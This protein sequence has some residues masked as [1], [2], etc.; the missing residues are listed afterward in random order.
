MLMVAAM[1]MIF[2]TVAAPTYYYFKS[3]S[4]PAAQQ[5]AAPIKSIAV[6]PFKPIGEKVD[7]EKFGFGMTDAVI[8]NLSKIRKVSVRST[9]AVSRYAAEPSTDASAAGRALAVD[10]ILEGIVQ[11]DG[12]SLRV[13]VQ[14]IR[15]E[16]GKPMWAESFREK[17]SDNFTMQDSISSKV[18]VSLSNNLAQPEVVAH[19]PFSEV[20]EPEDGETHE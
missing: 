8:T 10:G 13:S 7:R 19:S 15:V 12:E 5:H 17:V 20:P 6:M 11:C 9:S 18:A 3:P 16:D 4:R 2:E 14:L 1:L